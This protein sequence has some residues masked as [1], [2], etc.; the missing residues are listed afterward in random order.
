MTDR[1]LLFV[2]CCGVRSLLTAP[3][4]LQDGVQNLADLGDT[5]Q[6]YQGHHSQHNNDRQDRVF[7]M[8]YCTVKCKKGYYKG[9]ARA[10]HECSNGQ[11]NANQGSG[12]SCSWHSTA[13]AGNYITYGGST[14]R[15]RE[16]TACEKG[17]F[18]VVANSASCT[19]CPPGQYANAKGKTQC[20]AC[21]RHSF[22]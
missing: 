16:W 14:S 15:N 13:P 22:M 2:F 5:A 6:V 10:C 1:C 17:A 12:T 21:A 19:L 18:S 20:I 9:A 4:C 7:A 3:H 11:Y 8:Y